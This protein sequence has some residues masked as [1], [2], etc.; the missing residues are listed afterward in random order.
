MMK[1]DSA[2]RSA[3]VMQHGADDRSGATP[4]PGTQPASPRPRALPISER[5]FG[6]TEQALADNRERAPLVQIF[7]RAC[8]S[9]HQ[10]AAASQSHGIGQN[11]RLDTSDQTTVAIAAECGCYQGFSLAACLEIAAQANLPV[12]F[13]ALDSFQG[14]PPLS[15][16]DLELAP[17][18]APYRNRVF[19]DATSVEKVQATIAP[20]LGNSRVDIVP[21]FFSETLPTL[22]EHRYFFVNIDCDLYEPHLECLDYFYPRMLSGGIIFF[23]DY[24]SIDFPM[25]RQAID[26]FLA[27]KPELLW[28]VRLGD[29]GPNMT[30]AYFVKR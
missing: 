10:R 25:A 18:R 23:D 29:D 30:K 8:L 9:W 1:S 7:E 28:H 13:L 2:A 27:D 21:G 6:I 15:Q 5:P 3:T 17:E 24:H 4:E 19:F 14:L 22:P 26:A 16:R 11:V 20:V 12:Q